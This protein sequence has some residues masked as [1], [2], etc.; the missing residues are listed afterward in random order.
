MPEL[1]AGKQA[2][3]GISKL[4]ITLNLPLFASLA[5]CGFQCL[6]ISKDAEMNS[7]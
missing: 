5:F 2:R 1:P 4:N 7:A 3:S 6:N